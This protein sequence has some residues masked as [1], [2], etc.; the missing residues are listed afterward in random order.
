MSG[1]VPDEATAR[2]WGLDPVTPGS[3]RAFLVEAFNRILI[4]RI[5]FDTPAA[6]ALRRGI[7]VFEEKD[8]LLPFEE[9]KLY[10]HNATHALA[11]YLG[12]IRGVK[13]MD[14]LRGDP[15]LMA[16]LRSAFLEESGGALIQKYRGKDPLFTPEGYAKYA[17]DLLVRMTNPWLRDLVERVGRDPQRK[18]GWDDRLVGTMRLAISQGIEPRRYALGA[19]AAAASMNP[20]VLEKDLPLPP[21]LEPIWKDA[22]PP[23][24][25][26]SAVLSRIEKARTALKRWRSAGFR[27]SVLESSR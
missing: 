12:M 14:E 19:A 25:E 4:T 20:A 3:P 23:A 10:G 5:H 16:F 22:A 26:Q 15:D 1:I 27:M 24:G 21:L 13:R 9:A 11:A 2:T 8:D 17:D 18:L 7:A 6:A